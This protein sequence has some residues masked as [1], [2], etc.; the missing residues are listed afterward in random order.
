MQGNADA[1]LCSS[2]CVMAIRVLSGLWN[3][4]RGLLVQGEEGVTL[5]MSL[6]RKSPHYLARAL[7]IQLHQG[8]HAM[9]CDGCL[10]S[11]SLRYKTQ[12]AF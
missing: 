4:P 11:K 2:M 3:T 9:Y 1:I 6:G 10:Y 8:S 7:P 12:I 5:V